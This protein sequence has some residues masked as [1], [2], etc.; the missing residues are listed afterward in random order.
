MQEK[1]VRLAEGELFYLEQGQGAEL[2]FL[3]GAI[4]TSHAYLPLLEFLAKDYHVIAPVHPGHG[5]SCAIPSDWKLADFVSFYQGLLADINL[6]PQ[7]IIGHSFGGTLALLL[8][9]RGTGGQAVVMDAPCLPFRSTAAEYLKAMT[10][11]VREV[12]HQRPDLKELSEAAAAAGT[13]FQTVIRHP[14]DIP[15]LFRAGPKLDVSRKLFQIQIPVTIFWGEDDVLV[16][17]EMGR[18]MQAMVA[19]SQLRIFPNRGHNYPVT[20]PEFTYREITKALRG[21]H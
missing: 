3:H 16:P 21:E 19:G 10:E 14:E 2:L 7:I 8:A 9:A 13:L 12:M 18:Q 15:L 20:E 4:A 1:S 17:A 11:Q 5:Q 6:V